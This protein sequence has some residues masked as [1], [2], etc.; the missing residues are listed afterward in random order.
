MFL[1]WVSPVPLWHCTPPNLTIL[2]FSQN[3]SPLLT[4]LTQLCLFCSDFLR[5]LPWEFLATKR[6]ST[7]FQSMVLPSRQE[8][9]TSS[10]TSP[11]VT[12]RWV[13]NCVRLKVV[14]QTG[15]CFNCSGKIKTLAV[16]TL[17]HIWYF[18]ILNQSIQL[19]GSQMDSVDLSQLDETAL[20]SIR[21]L[22]VP[23]VFIHLFP[24]L[25]LSHIK[26]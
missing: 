2:N 15:L 20:K 11:S 24:L 26:I 12:E 19:L 7:A 17:W 16:R 5:P 25:S 4:V 8:T 6:G 1:V 14:D 23:C 9:R 21:L 10:S 18:S 22:Q 3:K 13:V